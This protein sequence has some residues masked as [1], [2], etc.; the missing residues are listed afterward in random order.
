MRRGKRKMENQDAETHYEFEAALSFAGEDRTFVSQVAKFL[1]DKKINIYY[2]DNDKHNIVSQNVPN[3]LQ[4]IFTHKSRRCIIFIS[5][6]YYEKKYTMFEWE[7]AQ[8]RFLN[9]KDYIIPVKLDDIPIKGIP[10]IFGHIDARGR[11]PEDVGNEILGIIQPDRD[12]AINSEAIDKIKENPT[13]VDWRITDKCDHNCSCCFGPKN[14]APLSLEDAKKVIDRLREHGVQ[15]V[16]VS[17]GEPLA[18]P[19][20]DDIITYLHENGF[21]IFLSTNGNHFWEERHQN[22]IESYVSK[23]SLSIDGYDSNIQ[24]NCGRGDDNFEKVKKI[25]NYYKDH[26]HKFQ[27][28]IGTLLSRNNMHIDN[29][30]MKIYLLLQNYPIDIWK[31]YELVP[32]GRIKDEKVPCESNEPLF[33]HLI[34][35]FESEKIKFPSMNFPI[36]YSRRRNRNRA[37]F[38]IQ[39]NGM[40][41][42]PE[43]KENFFEE[44]N[45][46]NILTK[47]LDKIIDEWKSFVIYQNYN[48]NY[49]FSSAEDFPRKLDPKKQLVLAELSID[50]TRTA[51]RIAKVLGYPLNDVN[52]II[53]EL[54]DRGI[55]KSVIPVINVSKL[56]LN[57][58]N[59]FLSV[60]NEDDNTKKQI[61]RGLMDH[62]S[63]PWVVTA[64]GKWDFII[65]VFADSRR[66]IFIMTDIYRICDNKVN[67][68]E[69][70]SLY[71]EYIFGPRYLVS[72]DKEEKID[73]ANYWI[74][75]DEVSTPPHQI[76]QDDWDILKKITNT[77]PY[78][79]D[80]TSSYGEN[81]NKISNEISR[82]KNIGILKWFNISCDIKLLN[83]EWYL[84]LMRL[85]NLSP[86]S[87]DEF[88][89]FISSFR[90]IFHIVFC[91]GDWDVKIEMHVD[92]LRQAEDIISQI[93]NRFYHIIYTSEY[94]LIEKEHKLDFLVNSVF[95]VK[96]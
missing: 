20:I 42:I 18:Y 46:G 39:P 31:I 84:V 87:L 65:A 48:S 3:R 56:G 78:L 59:I 69:I 21:K 57:T 25:L 91:V 61:L 4:E 70:L 44:T 85:R 6:Y 92:N 49:R 62:R 88:K 28:K 77:Q 1:K 80:F 15:T 50:A 5:K 75:L 17:G 7:C 27:I 66:L 82:L 95:D 71:E 60:G 83:Y 2:D 64:K 96:R 24:S 45:L 79:F 86:D 38:I 36:I 10:E 19:P 30:L 9:Q 26:D 94:I 54:H 41:I 74:A 14:I 12:R 13:T 34:K 52:N 11:T 40:V 55:L 37:Y 23:L 51:K 43:E 73:I 35:E 72:S 22:V 90:Q 63:I 32:E 33:S 93:S 81:Y 47:S 29:L 76:L 16:C 58:F 53:K 67:S 68:Y 89:K 8:E